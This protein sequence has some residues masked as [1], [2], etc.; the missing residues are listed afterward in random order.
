MWR[1]SWEA[2]LEVWECPPPML[3]M[4]MVG[5]LGGDVERPGVPTTYAKDI[6]GGPPGR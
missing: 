1:A 5:P 4:S 2:M 6:D 3:K